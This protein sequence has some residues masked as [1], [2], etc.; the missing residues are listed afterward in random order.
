MRLPVAL[1]LAASL[2]PAFAADGPLAELRKS[3][4][5]GGKP[6]P[7]QAFADFGDA[8]MSDS[9]PIVTSIDARAAIDSNR[10]FGDIIKRGPSFEQILPG[11]PGL[12]GP[13]KISYEYFGATANGMLVIV[14]VYSGG[15][16]GEFTYL[17][18]LDPVRVEAID[19]A[20][21]T[22]DR[23]DLRLVRT[24]D[25]GDRWQGDLKIEGNVVHLEPGRNGDGPVAIEARWP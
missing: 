17:H 4:T 10:Y 19:G 25:L 22:Y 3:F 18:I 13:P 7:P 16:T 9:R 12:N 20:A 11:T 15:G 5:V 1:L 6:I 24:Y 2:S 8:W 14:S 23:L 21:A